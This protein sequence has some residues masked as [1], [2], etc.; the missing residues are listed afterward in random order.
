M[1]T[2][3][4]SKSSTEENPDFGNETK[5]I[6]LHE[7]LCVLREKWRLMALCVAGTL[8]LAAAYIYVKTILGHGL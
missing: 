3:R 6:D 1:T 4:S 8:A 2:R 5:S 7:W